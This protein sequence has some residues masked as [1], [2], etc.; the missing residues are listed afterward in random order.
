MNEIQ[1]F[2]SVFAFD[3][4]EGEKEREVSKGEGRERGEE[5]RENEPQL[6]LISEAP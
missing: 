6:M 5:E 1:S 2:D 3:D 4:C